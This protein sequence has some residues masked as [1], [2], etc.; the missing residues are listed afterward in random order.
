MKQRWYQ[1]IVRDRRIASVG[2]YYLDP[3]EADGLFKKHVSELFT[4]KETPFPY[5]VSET[6]SASKVTTYVFLCEG[7]PEAHSAVSELE[8]IDE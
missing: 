4:F 7:I 1:V 2:E 3:T 6:G 5:Y 8:K